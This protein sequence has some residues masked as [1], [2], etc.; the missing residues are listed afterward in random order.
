M[1]AEDRI[2]ALKWEHPERIPI[3]AGILPSAWMKYREDLDAIVRR[4]PAVFGDQ[5]GERD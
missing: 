5:D 4:H 1:Y 3:A 2:K